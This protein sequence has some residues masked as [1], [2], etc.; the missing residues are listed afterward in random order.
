MQMILYVVYKNRKQQII[1]PQEVKIHDLN[2]IKEL[3]E[4]DENSINVETNGH[5]LEIIVIDN[6]DDEIPAI[7]VFR[8]KEP[9]TN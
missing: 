1:Q 2:T 9:T 7:L 8:S 5:D 6:S 3:K 4:L